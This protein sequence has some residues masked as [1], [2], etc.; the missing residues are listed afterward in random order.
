MCTAATYKTDNFYFG[1]TLDYDI[2]YPCE[3]TITPRNFP[4]EFKDAENLKQHYAII[5][6]AYNKDGFPLYFDAM[7]EKGLCIAGLNFPENA[8]YSKPIHSKYN[9]A[10][11]ELIPSLLGQCADLNQAKKMLCKINITDTPFSKDLPVSPLHWI[12]ADK[13]GALTL[14][15]TANGINI[16]DNT[17][18]ILTNNPTFTEQLSNL[19]NYMNLSPK[20]PVNLF[21]DKITIKPYSRGMGAIGLPGDLSSSS[22]FVRAAFVKLNS[23]SDDT[24]SGS[25]SQFFHILGSVEQQRGCCETENGKYEITQYT[26]CCNADK[27]IYYYTTYSN[28]SISAVNMLSC[29]LDSNETIKFPLLTEQKINFQN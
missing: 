16:Y 5:G 9:I 29:N 28:R 15:T 19:S 6:M 14:E 10:Q 21:S 25:I 8:V 17:I 3:I 24:E 27:G 7:N 11:F 13:S 4:F 26:S 18:G 12:I 2:S 23:A 1:R 20:E 22:R